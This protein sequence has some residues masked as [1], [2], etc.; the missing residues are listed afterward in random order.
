MAERSSDR[1][2]EKT[3]KALS[4]AL[5]ELL[6]QKELHKVTV[7]EISDKAEV[8]RVTFY[9]HY[10][11]V[12]DLYEK[13]EKETLVALGLLVLQLEEVPGEEFFK[14][15]I[16]YINENRTIFM[17]IFSPNATGQLRS[18]LSNIIEGVFRQIQSEKQDSDIN[19][20]ELEF[21][22]CY[23]AQGCLAILSKW[24]LGGFK[25]A[26]DFI[27]KTVSRLDHYTEQAFYKK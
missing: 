8:N 2:A 13:M 15:L 10:L 19:D 21:M 12:Y 7:Q 26:D 4:N 5:A 3:R 14:H 11:D 6:I 24:V 16:Q 20:K 1:R 18:K 25:E 9:N 23:R 22:S 27:I 17:M